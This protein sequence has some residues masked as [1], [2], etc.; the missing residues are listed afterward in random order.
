MTGTALQSDVVFQSIDGGV[1]AP[2]GFRAAGV[3]CGIK[4][5]RQDLD[6][7]RRCS[8]GRHARAPPRSSRPTRRRRR[9]SLVS[10]DH[11]AQS[12]GHGARGRHQQRLR[13]RVHGRRR[14]RPR[15]RRWPTHGRARRVRSVGGAG[16]VDRRHRRRAAD[17][18]ASSGASLTPPS[19]LS[20][21]NGAAAARAI[22]TTDPVPQ[23][24][25]GRSVGCAGARSASAASPRAR[26]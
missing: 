14:P 20:A 11:L 1:T 17:R 16:R 5:S 23:G 25:G 21:D 13:Q 18:Q 22:M 15:R 10:R 12:G 3:A 8:S 7:D 4:E 9:R 6:A 19:Q 24:S 2:R 26:A